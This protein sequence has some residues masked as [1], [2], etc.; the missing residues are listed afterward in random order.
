[1]KRIL[2]L[3]LLTALSAS[4]RAD[5]RPP[6]GGIANGSTFQPTAVFNV[7]SGTVVTF[8]S[9]TS[10]ITNMVGVTSNSNAFTGNIGEFASTATVVQIASTGNSQYFDIVSTTLAPGDW[11]LSGVIGMTT[12]GAT[13]TTA[14]GGIGTAS[15]NSSTGLVSG[16]TYVSSFV[17]TATIDSFVTI[18][19]V[20]ASIATPTTYYLKCFMAF[21]VA[22]PKAFGRLSA[23][24]RR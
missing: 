1:M 17:P 21:S 22:T 9:S 15:G 8:N 10:T 4:A 13:V 18:A 24:R 7:S 19:D 3:L 23:R 5:L 2:W 6:G 12:N 16:D 20:R 11:D 14:N